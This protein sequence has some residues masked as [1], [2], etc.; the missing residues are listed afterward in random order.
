[1]NKKGIGEVEWTLAYILVTLVFFAGMWYFVSA[2]QDNVSYWEDYYAKQIALML[3][4]SSE[5]REY[6]IDV[7]QG[8]GIGLKNGKNKDDIFSFDSINK[9]VIVS[10]K[11]GSATKFSYFSN[12]DVKDKE[13]LL[14]S[15]GV[16]TNQLHFKT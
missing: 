12:I 15:G 10:L 16:D 5:G 6:Y 4:G 13:V 3:D 8:V 9:E 7:T 1:M 11:S 14:V 2:Q